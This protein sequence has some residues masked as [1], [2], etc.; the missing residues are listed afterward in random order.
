MKREV[1]RP[2]C[3]AEKP[4][5]ARSPSETVGMTD[6]NRACSAMKSIRDR[7]R[8]VPGRRAAAGAPW[9]LAVINSA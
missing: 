1:R 6:M 8:P 2:I 9:F 4:K 3:E 5:S 7:A